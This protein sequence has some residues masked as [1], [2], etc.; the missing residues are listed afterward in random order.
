MHVKALPMRWK[1]GD[2]YCYI[3]SDE[4][5]SQSWIIDPAY[6]S[7]I[8]PYL[9]KEAADIQMNAIVN[10]HH[11]SDHSGGNSTLLSMYNVPVIAGRGSPCVSYTPADGEVIQLGQIEITAIHTPCHTQDSICYYAKDATGSALFTGDTLFT[12]GCG[13]FFEGNSSEMMSS[14]AKLTKLPN[15][16]IVYPGHEYTKG[17]VK[18][19]KSIL[20]NEAL[21]KL[22]DFCNNNEVTT[23]RFTIGDELKFNPFLRLND[24]QVLKATGESDPVK[25]MDTLRTLKNNF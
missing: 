18:W 17:N 5:T 23:G 19:A 3:I 8:T 12:A 10:T 6:P 25:V 24:P 13:R 20:N 9:N 1:S 22:S 7:E 4:A 2:N 16:T 15:D 14:L 21:D 11:H